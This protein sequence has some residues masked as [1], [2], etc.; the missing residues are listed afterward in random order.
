M[1]IYY[2]DASAVVKYYI[3]E[4]GSEWVRELIDARDAYDGSPLNVVFISDPSLAECAAAFA[5]LHRV[6]RITRRT[7]DGAY[8][9]LYEA[10]SERSVWHPNCHNS[11]FS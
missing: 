8:Q 9:A 7:R 5:V 11:R 10:R 3:L 1:S 6:K 4:P 2:L